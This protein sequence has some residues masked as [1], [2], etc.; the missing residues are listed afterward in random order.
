[1]GAGEKIL[2]TEMKFKVFEISLAKYVTHLMPLLSC[3]GA[4]SIGT[5]R[6]HQI[7]KHLHY[8]PKT[9]AD[10]T[11]D[12]KLGTTTSSLA[13]LHGSLLL[14]LRLCAAESRVGINGD[15][16]KR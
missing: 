10:A 2:D 9:A 7:F 12:G 3:M 11:Y 14:S 13:L 6:T 5:R 8:N 4:F 16:G 15:R 1:M